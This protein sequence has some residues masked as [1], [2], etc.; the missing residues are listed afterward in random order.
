MPAF[1]NFLYGT[2]GI[3]NCLVDCLE[4]CPEF[5][6]ITSTKIS[7]AINFI[8]NEYPCKYDEKPSLHTSSG[9]FRFVH[10]EDEGKLLAIS[11]ILSC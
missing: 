3:P 4:S 5:K 9:K 2:I 8:R 11:K 10:F 7:M 6:F 1:T